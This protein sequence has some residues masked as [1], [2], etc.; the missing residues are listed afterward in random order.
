MMR[1]PIGSARRAL[2]GLRV[3]EIGNGVAVGHAGRLLADLGA[4]VVKIEPPQGDPLRNE[5]LWAFT[6]AGKRSAVIDPATAAADLVIESLGPGI[7]PVDEFIARHPSAAVVRVSP[8]GQESPYR[9]RPVTDLVLQAHGGWV[10]SHGRL[11][12]TPVMV[13]GRL[14]DYTVASFVATIALT[15]YRIA[16]DRGTAVVADISMMDCLVLT[17]PYPTLQLENFTR[18]GLPAPENRHSVLPGMMPAQ[19]GWVGLSALTGQHWQDICAM[20]DG[21]QWMG[22]QQELI[23]GGE[24]L[25]EF[26]AHLR[27]WLEDRP[28][29]DV[30][31]LAQAFR[32]P[33]APVADAQILVECPQLVDR[34]WFIPDPAETGGLLPG[35]PYRLSRT[36][37][38]FDTTPPGLGADT[39]TVQRATSEP[40]IAGEPVK[41]AAS[42]VNGRLPLAG[43][44]VLDLGTFWAAPFTGAYL[45]SLGAD[46]IKIES[47]QRPDPFRY[48]GTF[49]QLGDDW[50]EQGGMY[51][52]T[53][54]NKRN[55][56]LDLSRPEGRALFERLVP[57]ADIVIENYS[58]RVMD[59][60][61]LGYE[62][63]KELRPDIIMARMP[64]FG[65]EGPW[66]DFVSWA[67]VIEQAAG[68]AWLTGQPD[69][70]PQNP[71]GFTDPVVGLHAATAILAA[72]DHRGR[73]GEGQFIEIA[74][75]ELAASLGA[76]QILAWTVDG[77]ILVRSGNRDTSMAP[78]GVYACAGG[79]E[80]VALSIADDNDWAQFADLL[81]HP[82]WAKQEA[83]ATLAGRL[84]R[85]DQIDQEISAWTHAQAASD[86]ADALVARGI[87]AAV[88][89]RAANM[90]DEPHLV[91]RSFYQDFQHPSSGLR[92]F[93][94]WPVRW[95]WRPAGEHHT[96]VTA[97]LGQHNADILGG[98]LGITEAELEKLAADSII[99]TTPRK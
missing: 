43:L 75:L 36:P 67:M 89:L 87:P 90:V 38:R 20:I 30:V 9:D 54:I 68:M 37:A 19:D 76:E 80:W 15:A 60:F 8:F 47:I 77:E 51:Q 27:R 18:A 98:I 17:L 34:S 14:A 4:D 74:Q 59:N 50:Q 63:L 31:A 62:R 21:E 86:V 72:L 23:W 58:A 10:N 12:G 95:S 64:G 81:G 79:T 99:G 53:N 78:Q 88:P 46:V 40:V 93:P 44:R 45:G 41:D 25:A 65:L 6:G 33:A 57:G 39:D 26:L 82:A 71:G 85:H 66:R 92:R 22:R 97:T 35:P 1:E 52:G 7:F 11:G 42:A 55:I 56:T 48:T 29:N 73:T 28:V 83:L 3:A 5:R 24:P 13:G 70:P 2:E 49:P 61:G 84:D 94:G 91:A 16:R 32:I 69:G 96:A